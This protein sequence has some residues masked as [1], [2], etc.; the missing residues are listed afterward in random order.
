MPPKST[1][2]LDS[3]TPRKRSPRYVLDDVKRREICAVISVGC[4]RRVAA[5]YVGCSRNTILMTAKRDPE[6]AAQLLKADHTCE[7]HSLTLLN[8]AGKDLRNWRVLTW[9]LERKFP[10]RYGPRKPASVSGEQLAEVVERFA[11]VLTQEVPGAEA[12]GRIVERL[13]AILE[14]LRD[15]PSTGNAS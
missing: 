12:Q 10:D 7:V 14:C 1:A 9:L 15:E 11:A 2:R 8:K 6:F 13:R 5:E 3:A 4:T